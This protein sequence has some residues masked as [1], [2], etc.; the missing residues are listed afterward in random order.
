MKDKS[1]KIPVMD[2]IV[3][4]GLQIGKV[5]RWLALDYTWVRRRGYLSTSLIVGPVVVWLAYCR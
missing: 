1:V 5:G 2:S 3:Q 4:M